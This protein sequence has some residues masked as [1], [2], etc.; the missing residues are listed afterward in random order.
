MDG[1]TLVAKFVKDTIWQDIP[2]DAREKSKLAL[3]DA[4]G[5]AISGTIAEIS[6][7]SS[8]FASKEIFR[9]RQWSSMVWAGV[10]P[11]G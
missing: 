7:I 6:K 8:K 10:L 1:H 11:T 5:A 2:E 4:I 9:I 3:L